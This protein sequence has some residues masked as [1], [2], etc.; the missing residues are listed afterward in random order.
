[1]NRSKRPPLSESKIKQIKEDLEKYL[2][3]EIKMKDISTK[4]A[5]HDNDVRRIYEKLMEE[6]LKS[7]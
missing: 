7:R 4:R 3:G 6:K 5:V 1:M 2:R